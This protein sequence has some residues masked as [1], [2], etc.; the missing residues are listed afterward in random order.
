[1]HPWLARLAPGL[2]VF[3]WS[4][5]FIGAKFGLPDAEPFTFLLARIGLVSIILVGASL[6]FRAPWPKSP[7]MIGHIA[8][9]GLLVHGLYL[10][11]VFAAIAQGVP[12]G[13]VALIVGLQPLITATLAP[14]L[15]GE[16]VAPRQWLGLFLGLA[17][18]ALVVSQKLGWHDDARGLVA[19]AIGLFGITS[20]TLYQKRFCASMDLRTGT[21][22]QYLATC[23]LLA[24]LAGA[25]ERMQVHWT[26]SFIF[27][28]LWLVF[29]LSVGAIFLLFVLIREGQAA[30]VASLFYLT[31]PTTAIMAW[32]L[33]GE[34]LS[35]LVLVGFAITAFGVALVMKR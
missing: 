6:L 2:F 28:L 35:A 13:L 16:T 7:K 26:G 14:R 24:S 31:P 30:R 29:A 17:G 10:A 15:F 27:A 1:M 19:A 4:T 3:L 21:A 25:S 20:G 32:A 34:S 18:V 33:F 22:I 9:A 5:G 23:L 11:G 12:A 8:I